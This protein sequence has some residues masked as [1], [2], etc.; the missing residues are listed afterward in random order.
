[1][2]FTEGSAVPCFSAKHVALRS[3]YKDY[4]GISIE[5][6]RFMK[7]AL[8]KSKFVALVQCRHHYDLMEM[9]IVPAMI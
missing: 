2:N 6:E 7:L 1:M 5:V 8:Y 3:K 9:Y 4:M